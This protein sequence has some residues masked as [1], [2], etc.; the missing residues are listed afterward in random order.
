MTGKKKGPDVEEEIFKV[1]IEED[2]VQEAD[3][4]ALKIQE[5]EAQIQKANQQIDEYKASALRMQADFENF[6]RRTA[7]ERLE[8]YANNQKEFILKILPMYDNLCRALASA[9]SDPASIINGVEMIVRQFEDFLCAFGVE[10]L[11]TNACVFDPELHEA[12]MT[13]VCEDAD[14]NTV[15]QE[16]QAGYTLKGKLLRPAMVKVAKSE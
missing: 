12:V 4:N 15:L 2:S 13:E 6:R 5:F 7:S 10:K 11:E 1:N 9:S 3:A 16:F 14:E 8:S